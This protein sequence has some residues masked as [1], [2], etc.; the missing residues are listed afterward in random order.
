MHLLLPNDVQKEETVAAGWYA[1]YTKHQHE[2]SAA[3]L[4]QRKG[5]EVLLPLYRA[6]HQ[7]KDRTKTVDLP[8]FPCYLFLRANLA[9][10]LDILRTPGIFWLV[11]NGGHACEVAL[12]EIALVQ[13]LALNPT[14]VSPHPS[15]K[16]GDRVRVHQGPFSGLE[17]VFVRIRNQYRIVLSFDLLQK[18][19][20]VEVDISVVEP[21]DPASRTAA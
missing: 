4:L 2:K 17:G 13:K 8:L 19:V 16:R 3:D 1:A 14:A 6:K 10:K 15:L 20:A 12:S 21:L 9:R 18:S 7:W 5:F 11:E